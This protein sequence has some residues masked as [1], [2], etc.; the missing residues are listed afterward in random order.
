MTMMD[1][2]RNQNALV[3]TVAIVVPWCYARIVRKVITNEQ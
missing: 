3:E 1:T 2:T